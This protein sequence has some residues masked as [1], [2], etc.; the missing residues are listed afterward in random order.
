MSSPPGRNFTS[1]PQD[2]DIN[3]S[4]SE[5]VALFHEVNTERRNLSLLKNPWSATTE[6]NHDQDIIPVDS[7][8]ASLYHEADKGSR[9]LSPLMTSGTANAEANPFSLNERNT[10]IN[11]ND[12]VNVLGRRLFEEDRKSRTSFIAKLQEDIKKKERSRETNVS[13]EDREGF[14]NATYADDEGSLE[15]P[16]HEESHQNGYGRNES[17]VCV[18]G[19]DEGCE[20]SDEGN[21]LSRKLEITSNVKNN[22]S[23]DA[24]DSQYVPPMS[25]EVE[26]QEYSSNSSCA[27]TE[28][29][30]SDGSSRRTTEEDQNDGVETSAENFLAKPR[31]ENAVFNE[32]PTVPQIEYDTSLCDPNVMHHHRLRKVLRETTQGDDLDRVGRQSGPVQEREDCST[33]ERDEKRKNSEIIPLRGRGIFYS[34]IS[35][36]RF[37]IPLRAPKTPFQEEN[38][39]PSDGPWDQFLDNFNGSQTD[40]GL[41]NSESAKNKDKYFDEIQSN[42]K[43]K[44]E[45]LQLIRTKGK[46]LHDKDRKETTF[47]SPFLGGDVVVDGDATDVLPPKN[48]DIV[49][50]ATLAPTI[51]LSCF[52]VEAGI[53]HQDVNVAK[54]D[55]S[56]NG[57]KREGE[58]TQKGSPMPFETRDVVD[59]PINPLKAGANLSCMSPDFG[60]ARPKENFS[61]NTRN[62]AA[63]TSRMYPTPTNQSEKGPSGLDPDFVARHAFTKS[64]LPS[65]FG[66]L[67]CNG[68]AWED[69]PQGSCDEHYFSAKVC[70]NSGRTFNP[71]GSG[72]RFH[73]SEA[74]PGGDN[75]QSLVFHQTPTFKQDE[76]WHFPPLPTTTEVYVPPSHFPPSQFYDDQ[77]CATQQTSTSQVL[78]PLFDLPVSQSAYNNMVSI[79]NEF[80]SRSRTYDGST[81]HSAGNSQVNTVTVNEGQEDSAEDSTVSLLAYLEQAMTKTVKLFASSDKTRKSAK[82]EVQSVEKV[83]IQE[84]ARGEGENE[85]AEAER[86]RNLGEQTAPNRGHGQ[87]VD[88]VR[89]TQPMPVQETPRPAC[90]HYQ[91][92]CLVKFPCCGRF[93]P[94]HRCHNDSKACS[95]DQARA[96]NATHIR[97][98]ICY[99][100]QVVRSLSNLSYTIL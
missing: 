94:C 86:A 36:E 60:G 4:D 96:I 65:S 1:S 25:A 20:E 10:T 57:V 8:Q 55:N 6:A 54:R 27:N 45:S 2:Q 69:F 9:K 84:Q 15:E 35:N 28:P 13:V 51:R 40:A 78:K 42:A 37:E 39:V 3:V 75:V 61:K 23:S 58:P 66:Y 63:S 41:C 70:S 76:S 17:T 72:R 30:P 12:D 29:E 79:M 81:Q 14:S 64:S 59:G 56:K 7:E 31:A 26:K 85:L 71:K 47:R 90:G 34:G 22:Q 33:K 21:V 19:R 46:D 89:G 11:A 32:A 93:Y 77:E 52:Q 82:P 44:D 5:K 50:C 24:K 49:G 38:D 68:A 92:R 73:E 74:F 62:S 98:T 48:P 80:N 83:G 18:T 87:T 53:G 88:V 100:E 97:C 91:R 16:S 43:E 95:D 99:H 67:N